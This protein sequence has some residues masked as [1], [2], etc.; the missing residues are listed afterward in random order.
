M[1]VHLLGTGASVSGVDRTTTMLAFECEGRFFLVD[2]GADATREMVRAGLDPTEVAAIVLTHEH[3]DHISG[4]ALLIEKLWLLGR[5]AP[6]PIFGPESAL[7]VA[8]ACFG[9]YTT[10]KWDGLPERIYHP[11]PPELGAPVFRDETF[12]VT[13]APV[14]H[15]VPTIGLRVE[16][17]GRT[18]AYSADTAQHDNV[19]R[20]AAG[21]DVLIHEGT[22]SLPGVHASPE[23]AAETARDAGVSRLVLVHVPPGVT[24]EGLSEAR[25]VFPETEWGVDGQRIRV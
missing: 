25:A 2:C 10:D 11:V 9:V 16:A 4:F 19:A 6:L 18:V 15:P 13:A 21:V 24:D 20:L 8:E 5:R 12:T 22:G 7:R 23:E 1:T 17:G 3:P 14:E